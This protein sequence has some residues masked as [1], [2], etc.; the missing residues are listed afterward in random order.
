MRRLPCK[1]LEEFLL[2]QAVL[3]S[4]AAV[5]EDHRDF[6]GE[7]ATQRV[8]GFNVYFTP[9]EAAPALEFRELFFHDLA[10]MAPFAGI[11]DDFAK[12]GHR[13]ESSKS[14]SPN[15]YKLHL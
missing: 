5:D 13:R 4:F 2:I 11:H 15:P 14:S 7:F 6:V 8:I 3:K 1:L 9:S 12:K 10:Q